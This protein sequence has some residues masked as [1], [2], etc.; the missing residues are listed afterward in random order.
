VVG[1]DVEASV[2]SA[3]KGLPEEPWQSQ[4]KDPG[5]EARGKI[6]MFSLF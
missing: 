6:E 3:L 1:S 2:W 4:G 5:P